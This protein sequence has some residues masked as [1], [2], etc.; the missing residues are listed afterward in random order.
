[1]FYMVSAEKIAAWSDQEKN[2]ALQKL[3]NL[4]PAGDKNPV[5]AVSATEALYFDS[6]SQ[7]IHDP[8]RTNYCDF[9]SPTCRHHINSLLGRFHPVPGGSEGSFT[10]DIDPPP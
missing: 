7:D 8:A 1:M 4:F 6:F 9:L 5:T 3:L 2:T 10:A